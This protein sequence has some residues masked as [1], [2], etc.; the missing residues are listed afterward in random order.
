MEIPM[1]TRNITG[2]VLIVLAVMPRSAS[3]Q[4]RYCD[5]AHEN[6]RTELIRLIR[7]E[8]QGIYTIQWYT[9]DTGVVNELILKH[10]AGV[11][12]RF[13]VDRKSESATRSGVIE[14]IYAMRDAG[15]PLREG[16]TKYVHGKAF[17]FVG[18]RMVQFGAANLSQQEWMPSTAFRNYRNEN[19][20][21][22]PPSSLV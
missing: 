10:R 14:Q 2:L 8:T 18:Q 17:I 1:A 4:V 16:P 21:F 3:A 12:V 20:E 13:I 11:P 5:S 15:I 19:N 7:A 6:C 9:R 22:Q